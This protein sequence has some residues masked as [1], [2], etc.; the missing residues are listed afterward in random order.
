R[1]FGYL[2][3]RGSRRPGGPPPG[4]GAHHAIRPA[5]GLAHPRARTPILRHGRTHDLSAYVDNARAL[6]SLSCRSAQ[7][8]SYPLRTRY[9]CFPSMAAD[10]RMGE[11]L[12]MRGTMS[13]TRPAVREAA[14]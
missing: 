2:S 4:R 12:A 3:I 5:P 11:K 13:F 9:P 8:V 6:A 10:G 14:G 7:V 1:R